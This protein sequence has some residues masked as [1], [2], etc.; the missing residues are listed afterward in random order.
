[1]KKPKA[2]FVIGSL[3]QTTQMH[4]IAQNLPEFD[5]YYTQF[6][7]NHWLI[8]TVTKLNLLDFSIAGPKSKFMALSMD[9]IKKNNLQYDYRGQ[10]YQDEYELV[11]ICNDLIFPKFFKKAKTVW[12]QEGMIDVYNVWS[13]IIQ[14]LNLPRWFAR[15]TPLNGLSNLT[16]ICCCASEGYRKHLIKYGIPEHKIFI[17]G[18]PNFD[19]IAKHQN[20]NFE[21]HG[22]V[23]VATSDIRECLGKEDREAFLKNCTKIANGRKLIIRLHPNEIYDRAVDEI[24]RNCP[25]DTLILQTGDTNDMVANCS[26]LITQWSSVSYIGLALGKKVHSFFPIEELEEKMPIQNNGTSAAHIAEICE[27]LYNFKGS[28][29]QFKD[30]YNASAAHKKRNLSHHISNPATID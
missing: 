18:I 27:A 21:H 3:N 16:D 19:N 20:N 15:G 9:Y 30:S 28:M 2:L 7:G 11:F 25:A 14:T 26:E 29:T 4:Q 5:A 23:L 22:H 8:Q 12:V 13:K 1:M 6:F 17:T 24:K 10:K